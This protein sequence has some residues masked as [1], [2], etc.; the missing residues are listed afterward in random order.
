MAF[1]FQTC[2][3]KNFVWSK[4]QEIFIFIVFFYKCDLRV[5][6]K[7]AFLADKKRWRNY[8]NYHFSSKENDSNFH[9]LDQ[10]KVSRVP[11]WKSGFGIYAWN[12]YFFKVMLTVPALKRPQSFKKGSDELM[13]CTLQY[14]TVQCTVD[15]I[16][17]TVQYRTVQYSVKLN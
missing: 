1:S 14:S 11:F 7:R 17:C 9:S 2:A 6:C 8:P 16:T 3:L 15:L 10:I 5:V 13:T 12:Y 4:L